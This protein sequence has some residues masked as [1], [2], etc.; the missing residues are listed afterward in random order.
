MKY[1]TYIRWLLPVL[2][3]SLLLAACGK[4]AETPEQTEP[5]KPDYSYVLTEE[6]AQNYSSAV[7]HLLKREGENLYRFQYRNCGV[8][9]DDGRLDTTYDGMA[10]Q[11]YSRSVGYHYPVLDMGESAAGV[12]SCI[13]SVMLT[14]GAGE[15]TGW[16]YLIQ[17]E[18]PEPVVLQ[19][20]TAD[21][22]AALLAGSTGGLSDL[23]GYSEAFF[24]DGDY[25]RAVYDEA[26]KLLP[27]NAWERD[28]YFSGFSIYI[29][30]GFQWNYVP[31]VGGDY[32]LLYEIT[33]TQG[34]TFCSHLI[35]YHT[36]P[37]PVPAI[38]PDATVKWE[39]GQRQQLLLESGGIEVYLAAEKDS[40]SDT[41]YALKV[42]N[43]TD[44]AVRCK[45][46]NALLNGTVPT[47]STQDV[48]VAP[49]KFVADSF[50]FSIGVADSSAELERINAFRLTLSASDDETGEVLFDGYTVLVDM[51]EAWQAAKKSEAYF[52]I[53]EPAR[54][55]LAGE[56]LLLET[57]ELRV[58]LLGGGYL[59]DS[60]SEDF[61]MT[62]RAENLSQKEQMV[63]I[64]GV[65]VNG[66]F[67]Q[68]S[69]GV[70]LSPGWVSYF[71][72][73]VPEYNV[74][75]FVG[76]SIESVTLLAETLGQEDWAVRTVHR[77]WI[78][79]ELES[80]GTAAPF[81]AGSLL[82]EQDGIRV[83]LL[84]YDEYYGEWTLTVTNDSRQA[85]AM[86][87]T[88]R[89][90]QS[91]LYFRVVAGSGQ[92]ACFRVD[93]HEDPADGSVGTA[94]GF[95]I[96]DLDKNELLCQTEKDVILEETS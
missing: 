7:C 75:E 69:D 56:Q 91:E 4:A 89:V 82:W 59:E 57:E 87:V 80:A 21:V 30:N 71:S 45:A 64:A 46:Y 44:S 31:L 62:V 33:D 12:P 35:P 70:T 74:T 58:T 27:M 32:Y 29:V 94:L 26:G 76:E 93:A 39:K 40:F 90:E 16:R 25:Y 53:Q 67:L 73:R 10:V 77:H 47:L 42:K 65:V 24:Y 49:G 95:K 19:P 18:T 8:V 55:A 5:E 52:N 17:E 51:T 50:G 37:V 92:K 86:T 60:W 11:I 63:R 13:G 61:V 22:D 78:P 15:R 43:N 9:Y 88:D 3:L 96:Y 23:S 1:R 2:L 81:D 6:Q 54:D 84:S 66:L 85:I 14:D 20:V 34:N 83:G 38:Q 28:E 79:V 48:T 68:A 36:E 72:C 41:V